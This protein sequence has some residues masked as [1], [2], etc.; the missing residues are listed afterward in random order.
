[1]I[2]RLLASMNIESAQFKLKA[3]V[4]TLMLYETSEKWTKIFSNVQQKV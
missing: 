3:R 2:S 4:M 1:M